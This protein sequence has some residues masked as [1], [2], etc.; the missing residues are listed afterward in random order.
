MTAKLEKIRIVIT[1]PLFIEPRPSKSGKSLL[2][3]STRGVRKASFTFDGEPAY[4]VASAFVRRN[5]SSLTSKN[6]K[7]PT[8]KRNS[9]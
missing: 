2:I 1:L 4:A 5:G 6:E 8:G 9:K 7:D 3:A